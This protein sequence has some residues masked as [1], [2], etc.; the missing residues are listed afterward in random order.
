MSER[1]FMYE[2]EDIQMLGE[3]MFNAL[4]FLAKCMDNLASEIHC[5]RLENERLVAQVAE[6]QKIR[7]ETTH[8]RRNRERHRA[9]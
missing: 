9:G 7:E 3:R 4:T 8:A 5:L 1:R 6:S 2:Q